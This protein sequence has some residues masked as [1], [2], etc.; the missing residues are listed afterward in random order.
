MKSDL[1]ISDV[2]IAVPVA[3]VQI[4]LHHPWLFKLIYEVSQAPLQKLSR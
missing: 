4:L 3:A 1:L 2:V